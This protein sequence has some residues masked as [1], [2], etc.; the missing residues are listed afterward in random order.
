MHAARM[1]APRKGSLLSPPDR[2]GL[3][4][5]PDAPGT[6]LARAVRRAF[7]LPAFA[8]LRLIVPSEVRGGELLEG[9][10]PPALIVANHASHL[11][12]PL[13]LQAL[14]ERWRDR[15]AVAAAADYF[16]ADPLVGWGVATL[17]NAFPFARAGN[18]RSSLRRCGRLLEAGWSILLFPEGTRSPTGAIGPFRAGVGVLAVELGVA[19]V[20]VRVAGT[21]DALPKGRHLPRRTRGAVRFGRPLRFGKG[22]TYAAAAAAIE[23][24]VRALGDGADGRG[25]PTTA[26]R[27]PST[28]S[29]KV[30]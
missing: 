27:R 26:P 11:D 10:S 20:P 21:F 29:G 9:L 5:S 24:A 1:A 12:T 14:P 17:F 7:R 30:F 8:L 18:V 2:F 19:V 25:D 4:R 23:E 22:T 28:G 6:W 16:F 3:P 13:L 15:V